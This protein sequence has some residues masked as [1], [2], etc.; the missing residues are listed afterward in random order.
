MTNILRNALRLGPFITSLVLSTTLA[1]HAAAPTP[2]PTA[3]EAPA[4]RKA[5]AC[6]PLAWDAD[7]LGAVSASFEGTVGEAT[8]EDGNEKPET[9]FTRAL[10]TPVCDPEGAPVS[11]L[12]SFPK[13][14]SK[15]V[16]L[17]KHLK[18]H[19]T[20]TGSPFAAHTAHHH[21][22]IVVEV[23]SVV[24]GDAGH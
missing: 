2:A 12:H 13:V 18:A 19:L 4:P 16:D 11:E 8:E 24:P 7:G 10:V 6:K 21:R 3:D 23:V 14:D 5:P 22:P 17:R 15:G 1:S 20:V 9:F